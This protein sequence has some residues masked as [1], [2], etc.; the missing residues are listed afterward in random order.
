[1]KQNEVDKDI[2]P[3][4]KIMN[5]IPFIYTT[6]SCSGRIMLIDVPPTNRKE[7][8]IRLARWHHP[9]RFE[10]LW[11]VV[12]DYKPKGILWF[13][14]E[15]MIVAFA[16]PSIQWASYLIR[17]ARL[18]GFKE[19]GIRSINIGMR[20]IFMDIT[21]TEKLHAPIATYDKGLLVE[22]DYMRYMVEIANNLLIRTKKKLKLLEKVMNKLLEVITDTNARTPLDIGF[23]PFEDLL[24]EKQIMFNTKSSE[25]F[26]RFES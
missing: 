9:V 6:S 13:K 4:L 11:E 26:I 17:L 22:E 14:Q 16:V 10:V 12:Q 8:S 21:S 19:S 20:H 18:F 3:L 1:M 23:K 24:K 2:I 7:Q 25:I 15:A 5:S